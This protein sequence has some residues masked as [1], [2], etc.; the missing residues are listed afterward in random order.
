MADDPFLYPGT[1]VLRNKKGL[2]DPAALDQFEREA[3]TVRLYQLER[4]PIRG[5]FDIR[6]LQGTHRF[7]FQ[8]VY[9]WAGKLREGIGMMT[10]QRLGAV[11]QYGNS[12]YVAAEATRVLRQMQREDHLRGLGAASFA[13]RLAFYYGELDAVHCFREGNSRTLRV[14]TSQ[15]AAQ[16][17][18]VL[19]WS[20]VSGTEDA[21][22]ALYRAR[23]TAVMTGNT[24]PLEGLVAQALAPAGTPAPRMGPARNPAESIADALRPSQA[25]TDAPWDA[26]PTPF[27]DRRA[28]YEARKADEAKKAAA[29]GTPAAEPAENTPDAPDSP[30]PSRSGPGPGF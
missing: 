22:N 13:G 30:K 8:D 12:D 24:G 2:R 15:L 25:A 18:H 29:P 16:A 26:A 20:L 14:F 4:K 19:D 23:D 11:V 17:G 3:A 9:P 1:K 28:A 7:I 27:R 6:H 5:E 21:R 10:K